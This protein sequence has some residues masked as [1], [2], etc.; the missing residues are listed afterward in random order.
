MKRVIASILFAVMV[1]VTPV[2]A[3]D[4]DLDSMTAD[5]L[6]ELKVEID[7]RL[8]ELGVGNVISPGWYVVGKDI[9]E[10]RFTFYATEDCKALSSDPNTGHVSFVL[11]E[12]EESILKFDMEKVV[13]VGDA[14]FDFIENEALS[15][16]SVTLEEGQC[17]VIEDGSAIVEE[18]SSAS[19]AP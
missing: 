10:G 19:W 11:F 15:P 17:L 8:I 12:D 9:R 18:Q 2:L 14:R 13:T 4:V 7:K 6:I 1:L 3:A 16:F 5:E